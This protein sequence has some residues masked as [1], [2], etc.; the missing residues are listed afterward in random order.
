MLVRRKEIFELYK[1]GFQENEH[2]IIP[3]FEDENRKSSYHL[4][5][6]RI[7]DINEAQRDEIMEKIFERKV[8]VNVH[9]IPLPMMSLYKNL[10]YKIEDYPNTYKLYSSEISLPVYYN[11]SNENVQRVINA[12]V[13]AYQEVIQ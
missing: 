3:K 12:V 7:K 9:F 6:L 4:F 8:A 1:A 13:E 11:L 5:A 2:F 10:G